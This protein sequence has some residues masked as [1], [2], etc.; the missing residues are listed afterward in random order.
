MIDSIAKKACKGWSEAEKFLSQA[1]PILAE[2]ITRTG[3]CTLAVRRDYFPALCQSVMSQQISTRA[4]AAI[5]GRFCKLFPRLRP[6]AEALL[7][8]DMQVLRS[9]GVGP[10][11]IGFLRDIAT[12]FVDGRIVG[13]DL[14]NMD[15]EAAIEHLTQ[16][17][18]VGRWTAEMFLMFVLNRPD[19]LPVDDLGLKLAARRAYRLRKLPSAARLTQLARPWRPYR[20]IATWYLW[21]GN[22]VSSNPKSAAAV[23]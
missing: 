8:L 14:W 9:A 13:R 5:Y 2:I 4:A 16:L 21:R 22:Q 3:P 11:K 19:V 6:D 17:K 7:M 15:D 1:D 20:T 12:G 18:G 10:Q 23:S